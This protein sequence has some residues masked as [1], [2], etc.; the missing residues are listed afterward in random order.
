MALKENETNN[1]IQE[2]LLINFS[3]LP[4]P[5]SI[6]YNFIDGSFSYV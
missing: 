4:I 2:I 5:R 3:L 1:D 6:Y